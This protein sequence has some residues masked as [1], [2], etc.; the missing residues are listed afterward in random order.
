LSPDCVGPD[1]ETVHHTGTEVLN[2]YIGHV[3][4][5]GSGAPVGDCAKVKR[6]PLFAAVEIGV[7]QPTQAWPPGWVHV[8]HVRPV[9]R[10]QLAEQRTGYVVAKV[11]HAQAI[12][13][14]GHRCLPDFDPMDTFC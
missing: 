10:E 6:D 11:N 2:Q 13:C 1:P 4:K 14:T 8:D 7:S 12:E 3:S 5:V 9:V